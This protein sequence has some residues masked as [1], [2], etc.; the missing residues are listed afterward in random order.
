MM[1][2]LI[3]V[4]EITIR[5]PLVAASALMAI[6][7]LVSRLLFKQQPIW[8]ALARVVFLILL[9]L[10][11]LH[12]GIVP[13][14]PLHSTGAPVHDAIAGTLKIAWWLWAAWFLV[15]LIRSVVVFERRPREG[16]LIQDLLSGTIFLAAAFGIIAYVFDLPVQGL[17]ATSGAIAIVLGIALQS[18]LN[19][20]FSG[21]VLSLSGPYRTGDWIN[22]EGGTEGWVIE[23]NWRATH[24]L[25]SRQDL[26][27]V[28]NSIIA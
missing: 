8:R 13:Y 5:D 26:A 11:L 27:I 24:V 7:V 10:L 17:L 15:A 2:D 16:K 25:T 12:N 18:N 14:Q 9:T 6:G 21:I 3:A 23:M 1:T 4:A 22:I 19:D 20:V 28:P